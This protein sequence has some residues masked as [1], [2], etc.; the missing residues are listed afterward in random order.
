MEVTIE[1]YVPTAGSLR[2]GYYNEH[3]NPSLGSSHPIL[4]SSI[5]LTTG[6]SLLPV[7]ANGDLLFQLSC[8]DFLVVAL[9]II[10]GGQ[11]RGDHSRKC[12]LG[13]RG[14]GDQSLAAHLPVLHPSRSWFGEM[15][16]VVVS[17]GAV[18]GM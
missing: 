12:P 4:S 16:L 8:R 5:P 10:V 18:W 11:D 6:P 15:A 13:G 2:L 3:H 9:F 7:T 14:W 17:C 1:R